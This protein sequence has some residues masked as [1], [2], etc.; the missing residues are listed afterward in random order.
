MDW[1][2]PISEYDWIY[3][4]AEKYADLIAAGMGF[5]DSAE[6]AIAKAREA[7]QKLPAP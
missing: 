7:L 4:D 5:I 2:E 1:P 3:S 6:R